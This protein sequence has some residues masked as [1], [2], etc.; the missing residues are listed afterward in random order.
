M[1]KREVRFP[2][3]DAVQ[4]SLETVRKRQTRSIIV[5]V[6]TAL[7]ISYLT[8]FLAS[9]TI[10]TNYFGETGGSVEAYHF[11]LIAVSIFICCV[12]LINSTMISVLERYNEIGIMKCLGALDQHILRLILI[13]AIFLSLSGGVIGYTFGTITSIL[14]CYLELGVTV[15][16]RL[17]LTGLLI[18][19]GQTIT[20]SLILGVTSTMYPAL[21][22]AKLKPV[23]A[24]HYDV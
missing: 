23:E 5:I 20:L 1:T 17:P 9:N 12:S 6:S 11:W 22:A 10:V 13:E 21:R 7:G 19:S 24:L 2:I 8:Y 16:Q 15:F 4:I 14:F 18:L 3:S